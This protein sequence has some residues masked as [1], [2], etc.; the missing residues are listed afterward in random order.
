MEDSEILREI[1]EKLNEMNERIFFLEKANQNKLLIVMLKKKLAD[2]IYFC[3]KKCDSN[4]KDIQELTNLCRLYDGK[5][6]V[7]LKENVQK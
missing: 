6:N 4:N 5:L 1:N 2:I 3:E 7:Y